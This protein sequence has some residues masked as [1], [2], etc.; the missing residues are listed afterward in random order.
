MSYKP[1]TWIKGKFKTID[2][3]TDLTWIF[4]IELDEPFEYKAGQF[5][6]IKVNGVTRSYSIASY[7]SGKNTFELLIVK[8]EGGALTTMLF[9]QIKEG[10]SLEAKGPYGHFLLPNE[11]D[12]DLFFICTGTGLA[13]FRS[14]LDLIIQN[15]IA[16]R[17]IYLI[18]GTRTRGDL[19]CY[20]EINKMKESVEGLVYVPVL[21]REESLEILKTNGVSVVNGANLFENE[22]G[23]PL[24][25]NFFFFITGFHGFHVFSGIVLNIIIFF[26]VIIG[27]Y[28]KRK[29]YEMVEK[30]GLYWHFVDLVWVFVFTF[31]YLV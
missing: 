23:M 22:Y 10:D 26:N 2:K 5:V 28:E 13:P 15:K 31:F 12:N 24:F 11:I 1:K 27:T 30:V 8:L 17:K 3:I 7:D 20:D 16:H 4:V 29:S 19:L 9:E 6:N 25:A 14:M 21:S 18:F